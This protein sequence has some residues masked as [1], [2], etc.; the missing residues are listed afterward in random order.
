[1]ELMP[2]RYMKLLY[3]S[4]VEK[5]IR[6]AICV[7][8][9]TA[10]L[11]YTH[12]KYYRNDSWKWFKKETIHIAQTSCFLKHISGRKIFTYDF[13]YKSC[14]I[15]HFISIYNIILKSNYYQTASVTID[16][17]TYARQLL[18]WGWW[19]LYCHHHCL[20]YT[21]LFLLRKF[22]WVSCLS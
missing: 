14:E 11:T 3:L 15:L 5:H 1:M 20:I 21:V 13:F 6:Y 4:L 2:L 10:K 19:R 8:A 16:N 22:F 12:L 18:K 9:G 17:D 7:W